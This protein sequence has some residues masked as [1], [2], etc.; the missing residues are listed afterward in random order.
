M[1]PGKSLTRALKKT[2]AIIELA[3]SDGIRA[4][5]N[6]MLRLRHDMKDPSDGW[7]N[8]Q[9]LQA[10]RDALEAMK[11]AGLIEGYDLSKTGRE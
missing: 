6:T 5:V 8:M 10:M 9:Y 3:F 11:Q 7:H 2:N 4:A 1:K